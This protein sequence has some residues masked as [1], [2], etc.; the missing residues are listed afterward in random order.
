MITIDPRIGSIDLQSPLESCGMLTEVQPM[1]YGDFCF[2]GNGPT[3]PCLV[4]VERKRLRDM[5]GSMR[6]GRFSGHQLPGLLTT[7][8]FVYLFVEGRFCS[9][10]TGILCEPRRGSGIQPV[11]LG[12]SMFDYSELDNYLCSIELQTNI[13]IRRTHSAEDT[14]IQISDLYRW[15]NNKT[16]DDHRAHVQFHTPAPMLSVPGR[17]GFKRRVAK[18]LPKIGWEKSRDIAAHFL[19]VQAM[20]NAEKS[21]WMDIPGIGKTLAAKIMAAWRGE[22][23]GD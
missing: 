11:V 2:V 23:D 14:A 5:L 12:T 9:N 21:V 16:W 4:G 19:S 3:G 7:Y 1:D 20:A 22:Y 6:S 10:A 8:E 15:F 17:M 18:E 13:R